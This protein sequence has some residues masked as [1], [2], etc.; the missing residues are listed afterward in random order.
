MSDP[1]SVFAVIPAFDQLEQT[2]RCLGSLAA[3]DVAPTAVVV[4]HGAQDTRA[5]IEREFPGAVVLRG[6]DT[7]W[8]TGATNAGVR[9]ALD[10]GADYVLTFNC[11]GIVNRS[12]VSELVA[13][14]QRTAGVIAAAVQ[15]DMDDPA[16]VYHAGAMFGTTRDRWFSMRQIDPEREDHIE[17]DA[18]GCN[19]LLIPRAVFD[20]VGLFDEQHLPQNWSDFDFQLRARSAGW[21]VHCVAA[22]TMWVDLTTT[23]TGPDRETGL[24][25]AVTLLTS[26]RSP[27]HAKHVLRFV[28]RHAP[29]RVAARAILDYYRPLASAVVRY[30]G[31]P[32]KRALHRA[33]AQSRP[34]R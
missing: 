26:W 7:M 23:G 21:S 6:D 31:R 16:R 27:W 18:I 8:W 5:A 24:R 30:H 34:D 3:G 32:L 14:E 20:A 17:I 29:P 12:T 10:H 28:G 22:S 33:G 13:Y 9:H 1:P 25:E 2:L 19:C 4:D 11:D 15:M